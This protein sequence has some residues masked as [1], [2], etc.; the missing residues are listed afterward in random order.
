MLNL[1]SMHWQRTGHGYARHRRRAKASDLEAAN[2]SKPGTTVR[3][4]EVAGDMW[5]RAAGRALIRL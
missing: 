3:N 1:S 2:P 4:V 5:L